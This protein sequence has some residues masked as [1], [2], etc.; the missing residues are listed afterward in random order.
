VMGRPHVGGDRIIALRF[1]TNTLPSRVAVPGPR[2]AR[3][4]HSQVT[5]WN[6]SCQIIKARFVRA[7]KVK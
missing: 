1:R 7:C 4:R 5:T 6:P 2:G 3:L